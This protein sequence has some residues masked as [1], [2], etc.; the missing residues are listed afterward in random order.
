MSL[1]KRNK[2]QRLSY[3]EKLFVYSLMK[4]REIN[5]S[6]LA[7]NLNISKGT[8]SKIKKEFDR[9]AIPWTK[10]KK[11]CARHIKQLSWINESIREFTWVTKYPYTARDVSTYLHTKFNIRIQ[12]RIVRQIMQDDL[13]LSFKLGKSRP[14]N[15]NESTTLMMKILFSIKASRILH[16]YDA[17]INIDETI[18]SRSTK[19]TRSWSLKGKE[20][21]LMNLWFSNSTSLITSITTLGDVF[22]ANICGSITS[23][24]FVEYL[25]QL[26]NFLL[27]KTGVLLKNWL[28]IVDNASIHRA[29][30]VKKYI[31]DK[32]L[33]VAYL[34]TYSPEMAPVERYFSMLKKIVIKQW[35]G[36]H[37]DWKSE[38]S[39]RL[40]K[41]SM[42]LIQPRSVQKLWLTFTFELKKNLI[43]I[44]DLIN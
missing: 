38:K 1:W 21:N 43:D 8:V 37:I 7:L 30:Y 16:S 13:G 23:E 15:Y 4:R 6:Q 40:L 25:E 32:K 42:L 28:V 24:R 31:E 22:A 11:Q 14:V 39:W 12:P 17:L 5:H 26:S 36:M 2:G 35:S 41:Q 9:E 19:T 3:S 18:F 44:A 20:A 10:Q 29:S 34:P 27:A 33:S